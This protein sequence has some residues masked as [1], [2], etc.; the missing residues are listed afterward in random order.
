MPD[1]LFNDNWFPMEV[2]EVLNYET[3]V[4]KEINTREYG[5][6]SNHPKSTRKCQ[7]I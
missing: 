6:D 1:D 3:M 7:G 2:A 5:K 4:H